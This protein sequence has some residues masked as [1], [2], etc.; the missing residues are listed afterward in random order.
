MRRSE[1]RTICPPPFRL[2]WP[3][4][5][6]GQAVVGRGLGLMGT[7]DSVHRRWVEKNFRD[8]KLTQ[9]YEGTN[10]LNRLTHYLIELAGTLKVE[11]PRPL[12]RVGRD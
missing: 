9:I 10:Q 3:I 11:L 12:E 7:D 1:G 4:P 2:H 6:Y 8:A 5:R